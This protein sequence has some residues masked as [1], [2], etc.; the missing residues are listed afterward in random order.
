MLVIVGDG[1]SEDE[2]SERDS[3]TKHLHSVSLF[4]TSKSV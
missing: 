3:A 2:P 4:D 1:Q